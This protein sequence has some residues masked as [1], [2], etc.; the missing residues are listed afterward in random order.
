[1]L[2]PNSFFLYKK[3]QHMLS[4]F[5]R[6]SRELRHLL[7]A[8]DI[9]L[10]PAT[11][12]TSRV[13]QMLFFKKKKLNQN[14]VKQSGGGAHPLPPC[15]PRSFRPK[16]VEARSCRSQMYEQYRCRFRYTTC[17]TVLVALTRIARATVLLRGHGEMSP[18]NHTQGIHTV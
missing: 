6:L 1:M 7:V 10:H 2:P 9:F 8:Q 3:S 17:Q 11:T 13:T 4:F 14:G 5:Y 16:F 12:S 15:G 18:G